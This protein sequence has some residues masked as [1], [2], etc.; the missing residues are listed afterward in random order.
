MERPRTNAQLSGDTAE[1]LAEAYLA[2]HGCHTIARNFRC[3]GGEIDL[4]CIHQSTLVFVEVRLRRNS[5]FGSAADSITY[6]KRE[7]IT[8]AARWWLCGP[9][10]QHAARPCRF[11]VITL[12]QLADDAIDWIPA[13]FDAS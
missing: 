1:R 3:K 6:G 12:S 4:I 7:R 11:D 13:A 8:R 2:R 9:G 5:R 10:N